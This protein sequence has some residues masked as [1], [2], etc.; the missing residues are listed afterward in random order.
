MF[1]DLLAD[2]TCVVLKRDV[3]ESIARCFI[4]MNSYEKAL[5]YAFDLVSIVFLS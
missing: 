3:L 5:E 4:R 1:S 2:S